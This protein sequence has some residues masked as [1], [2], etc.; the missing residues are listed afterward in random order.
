MQCYKASEGATR[1]LEHENF[2]DVRLR[3]L[4]SKHHRKRAMIPTRIGDRQRDRER[5]MNLPAGFL[6]GAAC[7][8][9]RGSGQGCK[10]LWLKSGKFWLHAHLGVIADCCFVPP[11]WRQLARCSAPC[12]VHATALAGGRAVQP[13]ARTIPSAF[14]SGRGARLWMGGAPHPALLVLLRRSWVFLGSFGSKRQRA[15]VCLGGGGHRSVLRWRHAAGV[16]CGGGLGHY[17]GLRRGR[18][19]QAAADE[20]RSLRA[21]PGGP[22]RA[23]RAAGPPGQGSF[24]RPRGGATGRRCPRR[25]P[26]GRRADRRSGGALAPAGPAGAAMGGSRRRAG[27]PA[28]LYGTCAARPGVLALLAARRAAPRALLRAR[29]RAAHEA[30]ACLLGVPWRADPDAVVAIGPWAMLWRLVRAGA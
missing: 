3:C 11:Q 9:C 15:A 30:V 25:G 1:P 23:A 27:I 13:Q 6:M 14:E 24:P 5:D 2:G 26:F 7:F 22:P 16:V 29:L 20:V 12:L 17:P 4:Y 18:W 21:H 28:M 8:F 10:G 19:P